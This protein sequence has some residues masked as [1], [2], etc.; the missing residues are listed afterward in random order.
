MET[1]KKII[2]DM[3]QNL[4]YERKET[5]QQHLDMSSENTARLQNE[6][7]NF[8]QKLNVEVDELAQPVEDVVASAPDESTVQTSEEIQTSIISNNTAIVKTKKSSNMF[9][10][11]LSTVGRFFG[12]G[13]AEPVSN[14]IHGKSVKVLESAVSRDVSVGQDSNYYENANIEAS[15]EFTD[16]TSWDFSGDSAKVQRPNTRLLGVGAAEVVMIPDHVLISPKEIFKQSQD[17]VKV[18]NNIQESKECEVPT[19]AL[20]DREDYLSILS[21]LGEFSLYGSSP[22]GTTV[23]LPPSAYI[24]AEALSLAS[25]N[26]MNSITKHHDEAVNDVSIYDGTL[27][28]TLNHCSNVIMSNLGY[29]MQ[30][31]DEFAAEVMGRPLLKA[32]YTVTS[33][34]IAKMNRHLVD[35]QDPIETGYL[36]LIGF[37]DLLTRSSNNIGN[38]ISNAFNELTKKLNDGKLSKGLYN[39]NIGD[40][41]E[42][43]IVGM[44]KTTT[45]DGLDA[46]KDVFS[47][48][49]MIMNDGSLKNVTEN[50][51]ALASNEFEYNEGV[52]G[53]KKTPFYVRVP[54]AIGHALKA[55]GDALLAP[56][57]LFG[58]APA[59][60][61]IITTITDPSL[62]IDTVQNDAVPNN[63]SSM[64]FEFQNARD[65]SS[66][67]TSVPHGITVIFGIFVA[68]AFVRCLKSLLGIYASGAKR[69][70]GRRLRWHRLTLI[71]LFSIIIGV[72]IMWF[73]IFFPQYVIRTTFSP[74]TNGS[75]IISS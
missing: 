70:R 16:E 39:I 9:D 36:T 50:H 43:R 5:G 52:H 72:P 14:E 12:I 62:P 57:T 42:T 41:L 35:M 53:F 40:E 38:Y 19:P 61:P 69:F 27:T 71:S 1:D 65:A 2:V 26:F 58:S 18:Y 17:V 63:I 55:S 25:A 8:G 10:S 4:E 33:V 11:I 29:L 30:S 48:G 21:E 13:Q 28:E 66:N 60:N 51:S 24:D 74:E 7:I 54:N 47:N 20:Y 75:R 68:A 59:S 6:T 32:A 23:Q 45:K 67:V 73:S 3:K 49:L 22:N 34:P 44:A 31:T 56:G 37:M 46:M 64:N 15:G